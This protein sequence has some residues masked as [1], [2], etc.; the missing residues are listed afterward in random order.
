[1]FFPYDTSTAGLPPPDSTRTLTVQNGDTVRL[2]MD[3]VAKRINGHKIRMLGYNKSIPGPTIRIPQNA[4]ITLLLTNNTSL[5]TSLHSHGI[6]MDSSIY[7]GAPMDGSALIDSGQ[8]GVYHLNFPDAGMF[9][10]HPHVREDYQQELGM[11]GNY[12]VI[13]ADSAYWPTVHREL[14]L[15]INDLLLKTT[16]LQ[17][18]YSNDVN[19]TMMGRFGN[20]FLIN[21]DTD[22]VLHVKRNEVIRFYA[23]N[24]SSARIYNLQFSDPQLRMNLIGSDV[25]RYLTPKIRTSDLLGPAERLVFQTWFN[26]TAGKWDTVRI[27]HVTPYQT[28][29]LGKIVYDADT[30]ATDLRSSI[31]TAESPI[32][33]ASIDS[34]RVFFG[35][36]PEQEITLYGYMDHSQPMAPLKVSASQYD[37]NLN[38]QLVYRDWY[39]NMG[40]MNSQS[41]TA[42]MHWIMRDDKTG[43]VNHAIHWVFRRGSAP[44]IRIHNDSTSVDPAHPHYMFHPMAHAIHFHGQRFLVVAQNG[45]VPDDAFVWKDTYLVAPGSTVDLLLDASNPGDWMFHC[46]LAEH[47]EA[48]MMAHFSVAP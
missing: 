15:M 18:Y 35:T 12:V 16:G 39:D 34:F 6:R 8:T 14:P 43:L 27:W 7:D 30:A 47:L 33:K 41:D 25:G 26:D 20:V 9:W 17:T 42:N 23:T 3:W 44:L 28:F 1:M 13:P 32:V 19:Y 40:A 2:S 5:P 37:P 21:G 46:H 10:Y 36:P 31:T 11:Y 38:N 22:F 45:K 29:V 24:S 4:R 48:G